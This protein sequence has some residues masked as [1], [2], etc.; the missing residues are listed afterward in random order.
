MVAGAQEEAPPP[1]AVHQ[2]L[3]EH[4]DDSG[5]EQD[6][7]PDRA[8]ELWTSSSSDEDATD[9][10]ED[11]G[12]DHLERL[13]PALLDQAPEKWMRGSTQSDFWFLV[14][15]PGLQGPGAEDAVAHGG[16]EWVRRDQIYPLRVTA[17]T[18]GGS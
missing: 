11:D 18:S 4:S 6:E 5:D 1:T 12:T 15:Y 17:D 13:H 14:R 7:Q 2:Q 3:Q 10:G 8:D 9:E 16:H